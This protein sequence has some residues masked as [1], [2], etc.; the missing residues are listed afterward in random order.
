MSEYWCPICGNKMD[1]S[2]SS[3]HRCA[4]I[5]SGGLRTKIVAIEK[6][7]RE[8]QELILEVKSQCR[9]QPIITS[10]E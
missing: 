7:I 4:P 3:D 9:D 5:T 2:E 10:V 8:L 6:Q 1:A